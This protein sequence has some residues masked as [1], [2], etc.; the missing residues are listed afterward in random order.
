MKKAA[1][2]AVRVDPD[3]L[4]GA[5]REAHDKGMEVQVLGQH[6]DWPKS[7]EAKYNFLLKGGP[8]PDLQAMAQRMR[9]TAVDRITD[10]GVVLLRRR[11][12][13]AKQAP[14]L[15]LVVLVDGSHQSHMTECLQM[16]AQQSTR[17]AEKWLCCVQCEIPPSLNSN[18]KDSETW[19]TLCAKDETVAFNE[20]LKELKAEWVVFWRA[21]D[22]MPPGY[23]REM[24]RQI[25]FST[26]STGFLCPDKQLC[27]AEMNREQVL[28]TPSWNYW[29]L[30]DRDIVPLQSAW[31]VCG[32]RD[33][34]G[35]G[36]GGA[37]GSAMRMSAK[38]WAGSKTDT[39]AWIR[40][41]PKEL[42]SNVSNVSWQTRSFAILTLFRG[43]E[44]LLKNWMEW[45]KK[46]A[47]PKQTEIWVGD[48]SQDKAFTNH[49]MKGLSSLDLP[50]H[51]VPLKDRLIEEDEWSRHK[52]VASLYGT[53]F[54]QIKTDMILTLED[55]VTPPRSVL[56]NLQK[57]APFD[58]KIG[59]VAGMYPLR[60]GGK[61]MSAAYGLDWWK[62]GI[63][64][65]ELSERHERPFK[66]H[67]V[68]GGCTLWNNSAVQRWC[69][70]IRF[71]TLPNEIPLPWDVRMC[72]A[73]RNAGWKILAHAG[74]PCDHLTS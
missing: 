74:V 33:V 38:G 8:V 71:S 14:R 50:F 10:T 12:M 60:A 73:M 58:H 1:V 2:K 49:L 20:V 70:P 43:D 47:L 19:N 54:P 3:E 13:E 21:K 56:V 9:D 29:D 31:R 34:G 48:N 64:R 37:W 68:C 4:I 22:I 65:S 62:G 72:K 16:I 42:V 39:K 45:I 44:S 61:Q 6:E 55:D 24:Q 41:D 27:D 40:K 57:E 35:W 52:L 30:R 7:E 17:P 15:A 28:P 11:A 46:A 63:T 53:M 36:I 66:V 69:L 51:C 18:P 59:A 26:E 5:V 23:L 25:V 32:L 67:L